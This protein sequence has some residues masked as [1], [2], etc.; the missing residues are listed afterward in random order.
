MAS[1]S[2]EDPASDDLSELISCT[3][4]LTHCTLPTRVLIFFYT[5]NPFPSQ[6]L[7]TLIGILVSQI[8][9][10]PFSYFIL[11]SVQN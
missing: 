6:G 4:Q 9:A 1:K 2:I 11:L 8:F 7:Y 10:V 3:L 5:P